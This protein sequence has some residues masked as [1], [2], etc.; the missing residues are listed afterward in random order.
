MKKVRKIA[1]VLLCAAFVTASANALTVSAAG[2]VYA[3]TTADLNVRKGAGT[4]YSKITVLDENTK[5]TVIDR[6]NPDWLKV[7]LTDGTT[8]YCYADYLDITTDGYTTDYVNVRYG[9]STG[10][11]VIKTVPMNTKV[12]IIRF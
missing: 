8:G 7:K 11:G 1:A 10:Y 2:T 5:V 9:P 4:N 3:K 12:D 6:S